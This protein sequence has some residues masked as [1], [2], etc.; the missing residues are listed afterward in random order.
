MCTGTDRS[1]LPTEKFPR[2]QQDL[3]NSS[4]YTDV[5][6]EDLERF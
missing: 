2:I 4:C 5:Q 6:S 3:V 1:T